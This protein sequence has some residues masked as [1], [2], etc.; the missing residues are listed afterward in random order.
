MMVIVQKDQRI[1][2]EERLIFYWKYWRFADLSEEIL[3]YPNISANH[4]HQF[5]G[6]LQELICGTNSM[7][8]LLSIWSLRCIQEIFIFYCIANL[9]DC[10]LVLNFLS[11]LQT[12][13]DHDS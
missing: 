4:F 3:H 13:D 5:C 8:E 9:L 6:L 10:P 2:I 11:K 7:N 12:N 1:F